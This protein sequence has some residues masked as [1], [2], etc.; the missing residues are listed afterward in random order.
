MPLNYKMNRWMVVDG[1]RVKMQ[2][3]YTKINHLLCCIFRQMN[4]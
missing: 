3:G 4:T 1:W 2:I